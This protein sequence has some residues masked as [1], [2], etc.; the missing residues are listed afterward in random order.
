[1]FYKSFSVAEK[2]IHDNDKHKEQNHCWAIEG[3]I[4]LILVKLEAGLF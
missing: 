1:M 3:G 2:K 4:T